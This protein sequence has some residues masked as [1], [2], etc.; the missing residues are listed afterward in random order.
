MSRDGITFDEFRMLLTNDAYRPSLA[1]LLARW[2]GYEV[3]A[4]PPA[5][6][7]PDSEAIDLHELHREIQADPAKRAELYQAAM[8]LWR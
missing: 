7:A 6:H 3:E 4:D 5:V 1:K 8:S 2:F